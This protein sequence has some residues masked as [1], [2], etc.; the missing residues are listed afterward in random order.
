MKN[1]SKTFYALFFLLIISQSIEAQLIKNLVSLDSGTGKGKKPNCYH[2]ATKNDAMA[3]ANVCKGTTCE[4][5]NGSDGDNFNQ[6]G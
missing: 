4:W 5:V 6:C 1:L 2:K 3:G